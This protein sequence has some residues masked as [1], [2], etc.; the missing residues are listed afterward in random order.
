M[1]LSNIFTVSRL[2]RAY[3]APDQKWSDDH[4]TLD[5]RE[6]HHLTKVLRARE[7]D[8]VETFDGQGEVRRC[9]VVRVSRSEMELE[10]RDLWR[11][12]PL[13]PAFALGVAVPKGREM[14]EIVRQAAEMGA[15]R[16]VPLVTSR[17]EG[18]ADSKR[19]KSKLERWRNGAIEACKQSGNAFLPEIEPFRSLED[20]LANLSSETLKFV[21]SLE[22]DARTVRSWLNE[23]NLVISPAEVAL[24]IGPEGDLTSDEYATARSDGFLPCT[25]GETVLRV[26]T[27]VICAFAV[28]KEELRAYLAKHP[29]NPSDE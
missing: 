19:W 21:A 9:L 27:A 12:Q 11:Q 22:S 4:I 14:D 18:S 24:L 2:H 17:S 20:W 6:S 23:T 16:L 25:F 3:L 8:E 1:S 7:G 26:D 29:L 5:D 13:S 10:S 15:S 28:A